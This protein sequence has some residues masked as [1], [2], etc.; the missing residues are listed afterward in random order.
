MKILVVLLIGSLATNAAFLLLPGPAGKTAS[1]SVAAH[2]ESDPNTLARSND[3]RAEVTA[4]FASSQTDG[5]TLKAQLESAGFPPEIV[6]AAIRAQLHHDHN[7]RQAA[8][9]TQA[10]L[11]P[12]WQTGSMSLGTNSND[13]ET[14][15]AMNAL[16][17]E[18]RARLLDLLGPEAELGESMV[19][20]LQ[21]QWGPM[22]KEKIAMLHRIQTDY[23]E[24]HRELQGR[25]SSSSSSA[26]TQEK[27]RLLHAEQ[28]ADIATLL[29]PEELFEYDLRTSRTARRLQY[30]LRGFNPSEEEY[31]AIFQVQYAI[32]QAEGRYADPL[33][34]VSMT[35]QDQERDTL[36]KRLS[37][38]ISAER[39]ADFE[40][41]TT[42][43]NNSVIR[44]TQRL[45]LP[46]DA[47]RKIMSVQA[48]TQTTVA[49]IRRDET[50][51]SDERNARIAALARSTT[52]R[53]TQTLGAEGYQAYTES[54]GNWLVSLTSPRR[55]A[56][57]P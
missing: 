36:I 50:L 53:L 31:R 15:N 46:L 57:S 56:P 9:L 7:L 44:L 38:T 12:F 1:D 21:Q 32:D 51:P 29:T 45:G 2:A 26:E 27:L 10:R 40:F 52:D 17:K 20:S 55:A 3:S 8:V 19:A 11:T 30:Q 28:R 14:A 47:A 49:Q 23:S 24:L 48:E 25:G 34:A 35:L 13:P 39:L 5:A 42:P 22:P 43:A 41:A 6:R 18:L 37:G 33:E 54:A 4:F 16:S